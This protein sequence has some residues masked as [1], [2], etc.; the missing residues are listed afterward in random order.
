MTGS[1]RAIKRPSLR[2]RGA[3][4]NQAFVTQGDHQTEGNRGK[5]RSRRDHM[6]IY[7][8]HPV[9]KLNALRFGTSF[10]TLSSGLGVSERAF[11]DRDIVTLPIEANARR[12][13]LCVDC[14]PAFKH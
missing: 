2:G 6:F 14:G 5:P 9:A 4:A 12:L 8:P 11:G 3:R 10:L 1:R 13:V 7:C